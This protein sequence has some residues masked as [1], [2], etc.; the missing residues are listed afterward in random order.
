M[1]TGDPSPD[2]GIFQVTVGRMTATLLSILC[3]RFV[4]VQTLVAAVVNFVVPFSFLALIYL[5]QNQRIAWNSAAVIST[6]IISPVACCLLAPLPLSVFMRDE[7]SSRRLLILPRDVTGA[8]SYCMVRHA[9]LAVLVSSVFVPVYILSFW[10]ARP[11]VSAL[12]FVVSTSIA[13]CVVATGVIPVAV[14]MFMT[15]TSAARISARMDLTRRSKA[16]EF[17]ARLLRA[18]FC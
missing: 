9:V 10:A 8:L 12:Q 3:S 18:P 2:R 6:A 4:A 15:P 5:T 16:R 11:D 1:R 14:C 17:T 13:V 7:I